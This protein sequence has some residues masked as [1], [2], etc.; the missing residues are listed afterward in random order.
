M[1]FGAVPPLKGLRRNGILTRETRRS[2]FGQLQ[3]LD[4][5]MTMPGFDTEPVIGSKGCERPI[6]GRHLM[7]GS[8]AEPKIAVVSETA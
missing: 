2:A 5:L 3:P 8:G 4:H 6:L 7:S 1:I